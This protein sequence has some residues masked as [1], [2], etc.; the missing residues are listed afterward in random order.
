MK[1]FLWCK[2]FLFL[3]IREVKVI[4]IMCSKLWSNA[5]FCRNQK[6]SWTFIL[7]G[8]FIR[9][10]CSNIRCSYWDF[11]FSLR[12]YFLDI[13]AAIENEPATKHR[14]KL[15]M[16]FARLWLLVE[17]E[18]QAQREKALYIQATSYLSNANKLKTKWIFYDE[19]QESFQYTRPF[20]GCAMG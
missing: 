17:D 16:P 1:F 14:R 12:W 18:K 5:S 15:F 19:M 20:D 7:K 10:R 13:S 11:S 9:I 8:K 4:F 2:S 6:L 3:R